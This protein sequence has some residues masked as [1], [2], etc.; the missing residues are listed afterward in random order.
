MIH[1]FSQPYGPYDANFLADSAY[2]GGRSDVEKELTLA[3][4]HDTQSA[5]LRAA[6]QLGSEVIAVS[7]ARVDVHHRTDNKGS[8]DD[9]FDEDPNPTY[10]APEPFKA[11]FPPGAIEAA[12]KVWGMDAS[13]KMDIYF[14]MVD[15]TRKFGKRLLRSGDVIFVPFNAI[16]NFQPKYFRVNNVT[17]SG[18]YRYGWLYVQCKCE[19]LTADITVIPKGTLDQLPEHMPISDYQNE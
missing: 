10:W 5:D 17:P 19:S 4:V 11:F 9:V 13:V 14:S 18:S 7:G 1:K 3:Q 16:G 12:L 8:G 2:I 6:M 15:L